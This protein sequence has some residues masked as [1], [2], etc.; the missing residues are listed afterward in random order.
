MQ[1][2]KIYSYN[3]LQNSW[4]RTRGTCGSSDFCLLPFAARTIS[5]I[6][7]IFKQLWHM[8]LCE[9]YIIPFSQSKSI[10]T[11]LFL[12]LKKSS[13]WT[14]ERIMTFQKDHVAN[15]KILNS[16]G[17]VSMVKDNEF[18][19]RV[20]HARMKVRYTVKNEQI[21]FADLLNKQSD[22]PWWGCYGCWVLNCQNFL[23][24]QLYLPTTE[25][26]V[27]YTLQHSSE[28]IFRPDV[29]MHFVTGFSI[30]RLLG[31]LKLYKLLD[32]LESWPVG[33][34]LRGYRAKLG[35]NLRV[36][37]NELLV[38]A[39]AF[40]AADQVYLP[41]NLIAR[42]VGLQPLRYGFCWPHLS[43]R[44]FLDSLRKKWSKFNRR[45]SNL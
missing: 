25:F 31:I 13:G 17:T 43:A 2:F 21:N 24:Q 12:L 16:T 41:L 30:R 34:Y 36:S 18:Q 8:L 33:E 26:G 5:N 22:S 42:R 15:G 45:R 39:G 19:S 32:L 11:S 28:S 10:Q 20:T 35:A 4:P 38:V 1:F 37:F 14:S 6:R 3:P 27:F 9:A 23:W 40:S 29:P 44:L 7:G